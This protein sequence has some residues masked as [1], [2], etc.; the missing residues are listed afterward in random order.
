MSTHVYSLSNTVIIEASLFTIS[1]VDKLIVFSAFRGRTLRNLFSVFGSILA[2][3]KRII[4]KEFLIDREGRL[5][6]DLKL[7]SAI[8]ILTKDYTIS[9]ENWPSVQTIEISLLSVFIPFTTEI[10]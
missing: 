5:A 9:R 2:I 4:F 3:P 8:W 6:I 7:E 10:V 1:V